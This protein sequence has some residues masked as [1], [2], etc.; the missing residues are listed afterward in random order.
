MITFFSDKVSLKGVKVIPTNLINKITAKLG[1]AA[2]KGTKILTQY[3][4]NIASRAAGLA[5]QPVQEFVSGAGTELSEQAGVAGGF[6][7]LDTA[8]I[9]E[10]GMIESIAVSPSQAAVAIK[11]VV[12]RI[13]HR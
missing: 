8:K 2:P 6:E 4:S 9:I 13:S 7:G 5:I 12:K 11:D 1:G 10:Q 3:T